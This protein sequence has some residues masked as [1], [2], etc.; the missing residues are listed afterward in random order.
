MRKNLYEC[1]KLSLQI[2]YYILIVCVLIKTK[3]A[4]SYI[5]Q[6]DDTTEE[7][8]SSRHPWK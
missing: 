4:P 6:A 7:S 2:I 8:L 1:S 3:I 5:T